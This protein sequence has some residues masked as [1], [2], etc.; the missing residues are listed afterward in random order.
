MDQNVIGVICKDAGAANQIS[1]YVL[2][3]PANY[4]FALQEPALSIFEKLLGNIDNLGLKEA[5]KLADEILTGTGWTSNF[6]LEGIREGLKNHKQVTTHL[7]HWNNYRERFQWEAEVIL[8][9]TIW[10]SDEYSMKI[11]QQQL[12][13][14]QIIRKVNY[15]LQ[16]QLNQI[17]KIRSARLTTPEDTKKR[18]L[19]I[20]EPHINSSAGG[21]FE[22]VEEKLD[23]KCEFLS[24]INRN[25]DS[26]TNIR[27]RPHPS[28]KIEEF[29]HFE[30]EARV[31]ISSEPM[32]APDIAWADLVVGMDS[33][34][35][36]VSDNAR[37][38]TASISSWANREMTIPKG[39]I[40]S[41]DRIG[42]VD[43]LREN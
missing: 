6:E 9:D 13:G 21:K 12:I 27:I 4:I 14:T 7:D 43:F 42:L 37:I 36:F 25:Q 35:L 8:P 16:H 19:F 20:S 24:A 5:I 17:S 11:A 23:L 28:E 26:I 15:Y 2:N 30:S 18:L 22:R 41:V 10:V 39:N 32:L 40:K 3:N 34:A 38:P 1:H 33:Y 29:L 31:E